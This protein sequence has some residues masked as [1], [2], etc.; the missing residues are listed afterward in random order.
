MKYR[1]L[2]MLALAVSA[3]LALSSTVVASEEHQARKMCKNKITEVYGVDPFSDLLTVKLA[4]PKIKVKGKVRV[5][6][7]LYT[8]KCKI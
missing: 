3:T 4:N 8:I 7:N 2:F 1:V 5:H 6:N